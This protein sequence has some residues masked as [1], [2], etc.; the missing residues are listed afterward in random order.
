MIVEAVELLA[1][2]IVDTCVL[3]RDRIVDVGG[4]FRDDMGELF[5]DVIDGISK[6]LR[7]K[8]VDVNIGGLLSDAIVETGT[9]TRP[10]MVVGAISIPAVV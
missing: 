1:D 7:G 2:K 6:L 9:L 10:P 3:F 8:A 5:R 4:L